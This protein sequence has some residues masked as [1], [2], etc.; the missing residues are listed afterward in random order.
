MSK[1]RSSSLEQKIYNG[2]LTRD[3]EISQRAQSEQK[4][5]LSDSNFYNSNRKSQRR[6]LPGLALHMHTDSSISRLFSDINIHFTKSSQFDSS[7]KRKCL[8]VNL[9][10]QEDVLQQGDCLSDTFTHFDILQNWSA[11]K[12]NLLHLQHLSQSSAAFNYRNR[13]RRLFYYRLIIL[14][15][16]GKYT[17]FFNEDLFGFFK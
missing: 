14:C 6:D 5:F 4:Y 17:I 12:R 13:A 2:H 9:N 11:I 1:N 7:H 15:P 8:A 10:V 16:R 3:L